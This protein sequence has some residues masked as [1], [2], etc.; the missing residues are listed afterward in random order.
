MVKMCKFRLEG[1]LKEKNIK[2]KSYIYNFDNV[3]G[4]RD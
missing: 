3:S 1:K 4:S 2:L